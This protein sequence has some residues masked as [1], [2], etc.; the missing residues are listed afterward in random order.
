MDSIAHGTMGVPQLAFD[1]LGSGLFGRLVEERIRLVD[2]FDKEAIRQYHHLWSSGPQKD[3]EPA[4]FFELALSTDCSEKRIQRWC[5][6]VE[7]V[8]LLHKWHRAMEKGFANI[9][10]PEKIWLEHRIDEHGDFLDILDGG[11]PGLVKPRDFPNKNHHWVKK[12][13]EDMPRFSPM[14]M[15]RF[16]EQQCHLTKPSALYSQFIDSGR[17]WGS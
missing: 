2:A 3:R 17:P 13:L 16:C 10:E 4:T 6:E 7:T 15:F 5:D 11:P 14:I 9:E 12:M 8:W 1:L